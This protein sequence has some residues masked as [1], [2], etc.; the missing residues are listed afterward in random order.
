MS[1]P[2]AQWRSNKLSL[3]KYSVRRM[4]EHDHRCKSTA[5]GVE[6]RL[7][8]LRSQARPIQVQLAGELDAMQSAIARLKRRLHL[9]GLKAINRFAIGLACETA[10]LIEQRRTA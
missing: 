4:T 5:L 10:V 3:G 1:P 9:A 7:R 2:R 8:F 6:E